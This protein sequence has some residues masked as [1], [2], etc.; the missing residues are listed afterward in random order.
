MIYPIVFAIG[1]FIGWRRA[2][3]RGGDRLDR[4]HYAAIHGIVLTL[5]TVLA[6]IAASALGLI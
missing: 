6:V 2:G 1:A 5:A 4:I 3:L